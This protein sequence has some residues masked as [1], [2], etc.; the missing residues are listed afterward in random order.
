MH[1]RT[2]RVAVFP[3]LLISIAAVP[4]RSDADVFGTYSLEFSP[5]LPEILARSGLTAPRLIL[6]ADGFITFTREQQPDHMNVALDQPQAVRFEGK[7]MVTHQANAPGGQRKYA[8]PTDAG[9]I[10]RHPFAPQV[11]PVSFQVSYGRQTIFFSGEIDDR[12]PHG[13]MSV[14]SQRAWGMAHMVVMPEVG[15][16]V[17]YT[18]VPLGTWTAKRQ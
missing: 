12:P 8:L 6:P 9:C 11:L 5:S 2:G 17:G 18:M 16:T 15:H 3:L 4:A 10:P 7:G 1:R 14:G 13:P